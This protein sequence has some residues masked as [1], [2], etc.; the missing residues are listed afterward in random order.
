MANKALQPVWFVLVI[1][2]AVIAVSALA[3]LREPKERIPWRTDY[4]A[5]EAEAR[6]A[7]KPLLVYFTATWC[8]PCQEMKRTT[9][10]DARVE[11]ALREYVP[12]KVDVDQQPARAEA[13]A[14]RGVPAC[15]VVTPG[16]EAE[17]RRTVG[18]MSPDEFV[19]WL[20]ATPQ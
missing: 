2:V 19:A 8:G 3:K 1:L 17:A 16:R 10:A 13:F 20:Q 5:A 11:L 14:V 18:F 6:A 7:G 15:A 12:V 9:W 4:A